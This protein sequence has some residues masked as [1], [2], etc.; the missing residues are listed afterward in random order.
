[1]EINWKELAQTEGYKSLKAAYIRDV[2]KAG[3]IQAK[4]HRPM[5]DK[6]EF[7][8]LFRWVI[9]RAKHYAIRKGVPIED[10]L[11]FWE[12]KRGYWWLN[13]YQEGNQPKLPSGKP[14]NV[15]YEKPETYIRSRWMS[16]VD[17]FQRLRKERTRVA[18][19]LR[20]MTGKKA[21]WSLSMK[22]VK[23]RQRARK[24]SL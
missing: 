6:A 17:Y 9:D 14:R 18:R 3:E 7:L 20:N 21:R 2:Q 24:K 10:V 22:R 15:Q 16:K 13:Y 11:N 23:A 8:K 5:R 12:S 1:M 19:E 4:G